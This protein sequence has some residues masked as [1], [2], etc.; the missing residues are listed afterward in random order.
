AIIYPDGSVEFRDHGAAADIEIFGLDLR[1]R[2]FREPEPERHAPWWS[3]LLYESLYPRRQS[4]GPAPIF[5]GFGVRFGGLA[6]GPR[7]S[8]HRS[9]KQAFLAATEALR[10]RLANAWYK[11]RLQAEL[12]DLGDQLLAVW[13]DTSLPLAERKR[14]IF[15]R[16]AECEDPDTA[17]R[18]ELDNMRL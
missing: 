16:W 8:R 7:K 6:D 14:R 11:Q 17:R 5:A 9:A 4:L 15:E 13:H 12:A 18:T 3:G 1:R 10:F 2:R